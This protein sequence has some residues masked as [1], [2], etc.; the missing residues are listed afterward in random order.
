MPR[1][2]FRYLLLAVL[3]A[4]SCQVRGNYA[5]KLFDIL[6]NP[7]ASPAPPFS[8]RGVS[9]GIASSD[10]RDD[11]ILA[12][13][14][15]PYRSERQFEDAVYGHRPGDPITLTLSEPNGHA[16]EKKVPVDSERTNF[17]TGSQWALAILMEFPVPLV[18]IFLGAF[19]VAVRPSD[20]NAWLLLL[21]LLSFSEIS[22]RDYGPE[23]SFYLV[24]NSVMG[25]LWPV[26]MMLFGIYFPERSPME[27]RRPWLKYLFVIPF[28]AVPLLSTGIGLLWI[29]DINAAVVYRPLYVRLALVQTIVGMIAVSTYFANIGIKQRIASADSRRRLRI[30]SWGSSI[31]LTPILLLVIFSIARGNGIILAGVP[32]PI[33]VVALLFLALFPFT[34]A[35]AIVV[36]RAMDL[37]FVVRRSIQYGLARGGFQV[38]RLILVCAA[39]Y[40]L[41]AVVL[42]GNDEWRDLEFAGIGL[43]LF[44]LRR[45]RAN[46]ASQ[47]LDRRFFRE[48]YDAERILAGLAK[49]AGGFV[50]IGPLLEG[51]A[52]RISEALHVPD[53]VILLPEGDRFVPRYSTRPGQPMNIDAAGRI[54]KNLRERNEALEIYF[55]KPP[56]WLRS[57]SAEELQTLDFMRTQLLLPIAGRGELIGIMSLGAKLSEAP[58]SGTDIR[59][60]QT[61]ASQMS[62][63]IENSRLAASLAAE[64]AERERANREI[65]IA[66]EVQERLFPQS[67]PAIPGL[68]CAGYCR[69]ARGVGGDYYDFLALEGGRLG[70][71]IG[72]VSGKGIAAA[73]LMASLQASLRGQ[74]AA[75]VHDLAVL[76]R[77]V[78]KLVYEASTSNR[79]A[80]FF[81]GEYDPATRL[82]DFVNAGHNAPVI[83]RGEEVVRLEAGGPVVGLLPGARYAEDRC[84]LEPGDILVAF[85][86]GIS[87]AQN[88][89]EEEWEEDRF[90]AAARRC[91]GLA[92]REMIRAIFRDADE[93]T[94]KAK[95]YDDMTLLIVRL[96]AGPIQ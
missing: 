12:I 3:V 56:L 82:L 96:S 49:E 16:I 79:Y 91:S 54:A 75:G 95:Q 14:G 43:G 63:A 22:A 33:S 76:M 83:L 9:R 51:V 81:Y 45:S 40:L 15:R 66:R 7:G 64:A 87:E 20:G 61:I 88:E 19:A 80:T 8:L 42:R 86:D 32:L 31:S 17:S 68:D 13:N 74:A 10:L 59:L 2:A 46:N 35:Y 57:L 36:E 90:I 94:G 38:G 55:D 18:C 60:L 5:H 77:N 29:Y 58:Y 71:A 6:I 23:S 37:R 11:E 47:W 62:L 27:K 30:L 72:D 84:R 53:I 41:R 1:Y 48:A 25:G 34:L 73:L 65:E 44:I 4:C 69:P 67:I 89:A 92:A 28:A 93:F 39:I 21:L 24:W 85:T 78:N 26:F 52:S 70:I 50:E